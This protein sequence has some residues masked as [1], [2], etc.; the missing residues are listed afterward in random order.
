MNKILSLLFVICFFTLITCKSSKMDYRV[1]ECFSYR[2]ETEEQIT[3]STVTFKE[4]AKELNQVRYCTHHPFILGELLFEE[5][6]HW[7]AIYVDKNKKSVLLFW[8]N[9]KIKGID[10]PF[11]YGTTTYDDCLSSIIVLDENDND[12]LSPESEYRDILLENFRDRINSYD[13]KKRS[14]FS[15]YRRYEL[16][17]HYKELYNK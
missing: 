17:P 14:T 8:Q 4:A 9:I 11:T 12:M 5:L 16:A 10:K 1:D 7:D 15:Q 13:T 3:W 6:G 2:I